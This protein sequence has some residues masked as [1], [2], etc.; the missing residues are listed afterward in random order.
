MAKYGDM[1]IE[2]LR[3][4]KDGTVTESQFTALQR[5]LNELGDREDKYASWLQTIGNSPTFTSPTIR[6]PMYL[7]T[8]LHTYQFFVTSPI[9]IANDTKTYLTF[10]TFLGD[11]SIFSVDAGDHTIIRSP[12]G[13]PGLTIDGFVQ[14]E[15]GATGYRSL[16]AEFFDVNGT[17][18]GSQTFL[19]EPGLATVSS[20]RSF[21]YTDTLFTTYSYF[22]IHVKHTQGAAIDV[23]ACALAVRLA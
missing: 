18:A 6:S 8:P 10:D 11:D 15:A 9:E 14:W 22:K 5:T 12:Q 17:S 23:E 7:S 20:N 13:V 1:V 19:R 2:T 4:V 21:S 16:A 3:A